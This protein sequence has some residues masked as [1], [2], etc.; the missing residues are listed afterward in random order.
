MGPGKTPVM[1]TSR[2]ILKFAAAFAF[3]I[4]PLACFGSSTIT[5]K[6]V[7]TLSAL[8]GNNTSAAN[9]FIS[10]TNGN[11]GAANISKA[12][13][14]TLLYPGAPTKIYA[15]LMLWFGGTGHMNVGYSSTSA[16]Q[17]KRQIDDMVSRG[18]NG[19]I[20]DWYGPGNA[21]D[22]AAQLV[23]AEAEA[24]PGFTFAIMVDKGA[25][26]KSSCTTCTAQQILIQQLQ[27]VEQEYFPSPAYMRIN[28]RPVVTNF[29]LD[30]HYSI[31]W[32]AL[33]AAVSSNPVFIFQNNSGFSHLLSGGSY[34]WV[35]P[36]AS[37]FGMSYLNSFYAAGLLLP[38]LET[39]GSAY[40]GFNDTL[41]SWGTG[42]VMAQQ[43]GQT[44]LQ[45][46]SAINNLYNAANPLS[47]LQLVTWNDY[48]EGTEIESGIDNCLSMNAQMAGSSL[49][50]S[51]S[52]N[53]NTVDHYTAYISS[54]GQNLMPLTDLAVGIH[55]L[56][57][58]SYSLP[59]GHYTIYVQAMGRAGFTNQMSGAVA[60]APQ[61]ASGAPVSTSPTGITMAA[62]PQSLT[63]SRGD[64][65]N[66]QVTVSPSNGAFS[67]QVS[68]SCANLSSDL[69][70]SF[71]PSTIIPNSTGAK[72]TLTI[73]PT[74]LSS[75][76]KPDR[77]RGREN[78]PPL[79]F[80]FY[81]GSIGMVWAGAL[82]K[83]QLRR[84]FLLCGICGGILLLS[85]CG[86]GT[87]SPSAPNAAQSSS[88]TYTVTLNASS[89]SAQTSA[90]M[91]LTVQ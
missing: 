54:D 73:S 30:V 50:W 25:I 15:H 87:A 89:G 71:S 75:A 62:S 90:T 21:E 26:S 7:T 11:E 67:G 9:S 53:E 85:S 77:S 60:Y 36:T 69:S 14:H 40:K 59:T 24:H 2:C 37:N 82:N 47:A 6:P 39:V 57:L 29:D 58:C 46:F 49:Q 3:A 84:I 22:Q 13:I 45:T 88:K 18:I 17:I 4:L 35:M 10:Q 32:N 56:D 80:A 33:Q 51:V 61:C 5:I 41:A 74:S 63:I 66:I 76:I 78:G 42:R 86:G 31:D 23:M 68:L 52:G 70:C 16:A 79:Y 43:C 48:E 19:V 28:G 12:D 91:T 44:W 64:S 8:T 72:S 20:L 38:N 1:D 65:A 83:K 55:N 27:Y 81:F 34:S